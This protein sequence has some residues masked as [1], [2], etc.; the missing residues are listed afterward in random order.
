MMKENSELLDVADLVED[1]FGKC[2]GA[3]LCQGNAELDLADS[4]KDS[5]TT[6]GSK[7][8]ITLGVDIGIEG[9]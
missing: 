3:K 2:A 4:L 6:T 9:D 7:A 1:V 8:E 5:M